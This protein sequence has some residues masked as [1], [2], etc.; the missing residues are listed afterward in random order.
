MEILK[1]FRK[2]DVSNIPVI[3]EDKFRIFYKFE[4]D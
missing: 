3:L 1:I 4:N 2:Y